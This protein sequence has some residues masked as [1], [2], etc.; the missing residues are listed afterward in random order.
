[1]V[2]RAQTAVTMLLAGALSL[3][4]GFLR[5]DDGDD[6]VQAFLARKVRWGADYDMALAGDSR[7]NQGI[8]PSEMADTLAGYRIANFGFGHVALHGEYLDAVENLLDPRSERRTI[9]FGVSPLSLTP[10]AAESNQF[11]ELR[12]QH[13]AALEQQVK[14][15]DFF[16][17]FRPVDLQR[18]RLIR[19]TDH[20]DR[21]AFL[22]PD[23]WTEATMEPEKPLI[24]I[25]FY[26]DHYTKSTVSEEIIDALVA[27]VGRWVDSG[28]SVFGFYMPTS[29]PM[30]ELEKQISGFDEAALQRKFESAGGI[31]LSFRA[32]KYHSYDANHL[33]KDS[34]RRFSRQ[35]A[36][37]IARKIGKGR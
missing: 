15:K 29:P 24:S 34:A 13:P 16:R 25:D 32:D 28:I 21:I 4:V 35:L 22:H 33:R 27:R 19:T 11:L 6:D 17:F 14:F 8:A 1:M 36:R 30:I 9:V 3:A 37:T 31:W 18:D 26:R 10:M 5:P 20:L 7:V 2:W 12:R 23:G